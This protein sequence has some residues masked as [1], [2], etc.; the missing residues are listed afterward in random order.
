MVIKAKT[1]TR[2]NI[3]SYI[4]AHDTAQP[5]ELIAHFQLHPTLIHRYL[6]DLLQ[7]GVIRKLGAVPKVYY[8]LSKKA[9]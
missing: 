9:E 5:K 1:T 6:K 3:I 8:T 7:E 4:T 2:E